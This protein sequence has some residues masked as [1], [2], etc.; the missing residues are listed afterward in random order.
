M[1]KKFKLFATI[2]SLAI[3][4]CMMTIGVLAAA[5][6]TLTIDTSV[7]FEATNVS[8]EYKVTK[9][10]P[11][12]AWSEVTAET[13]G[14]TTLTT[15]TES[16]TFTNKLNETNIV[17]GYY[18]TIKNTYTAN[19]VINVAFTD[20]ATKT[21]KGWTVTSSCEETSINPGDSIVAYVYVTIDSKN[22]VDGT[23]ITL[24]TAFELT[25]ATA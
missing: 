19:Q 12:T 20:V 3:A 10:E 13:E 8:A 7:Q 11:T 1:K 14:L 5:S 23:E 2:G 22:I 16:V 6:V 15:K 21:G 18:V 9:V 25:L 4:I 24:D 17:A